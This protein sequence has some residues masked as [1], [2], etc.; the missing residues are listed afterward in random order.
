VLSTVLCGF[1]LLTDTNLA[2]HFQGASINSQ[3]FKAPA[4]LSCQGH[5]H[6]PRH[7]HA[8]CNLRLLSCVHVLS[9]SL[10]RCLSIF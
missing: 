1:A 5:M 3:Q 8:L 2:V 6:C 10:A 7:H 4:G 9:L